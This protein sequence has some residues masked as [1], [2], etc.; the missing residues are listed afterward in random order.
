MQ[1]LIIPYRRS[2]VVGECIE[3][4]I[5]WYVWLQGFGK[6]CG[7]ERKRLIINPLIRGEPEGIRN[8]VKKNQDTEVSFYHAILLLRK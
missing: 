3:N 2:I 1:G 5:G 8:E 4:E 7:L 6:N